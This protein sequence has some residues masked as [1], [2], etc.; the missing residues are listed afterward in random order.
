L[1]IYEYVCHSCGAAFEALVPYRE[2]DSMVCEQCGSGDVER[3]VSVCCGSAS[4]GSEGDAAPS[5][6]SGG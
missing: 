6:F 2:A 5:C 1:P 3:L 4:S